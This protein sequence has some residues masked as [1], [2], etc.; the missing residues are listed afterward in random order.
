M[1]PESFK[2]LLELISSVIAKQTTRLC[3]PSLLNIELQ[4]EHAFEMRLAVRHL[5]SSE[6]Q[7]SLVWSYQLD[8]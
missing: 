3:E 8:E 7:Q 6:T 4:N 2:N 5:A 1:S